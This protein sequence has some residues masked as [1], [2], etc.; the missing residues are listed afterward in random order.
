MDKNRLFQQA[1]TDPLLL[2]D[3]QQISRDIPLVNNRNLKIIRRYYVYTV[4]MNVPREQALSELRQEYSLEVKVIK[5]IIDS[6]QPEFDEMCKTQRQLD[7]YKTQEGCS[8]IDW[9]YN[10]LSPS[11]LH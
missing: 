2:S 1:I 9:E 8:H 10:P 11:N 7:W 6:R 4:L 3:R 5:K